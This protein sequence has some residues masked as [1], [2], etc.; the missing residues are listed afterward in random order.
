MNKSKSKCIFIRAGGITHQV[1]YQKNPGGPNGFIFE[2]KGNSQKPQQHLVNMLGALS[3]RVVPQ[4]SNLDLSVNY[5]GFGS[6]HI[7]FL[8][9]GF[10]AVL[11]IERDNLYAEEVFGHTTKDY[12]YSIKSEITGRACLAYCSL[13]LSF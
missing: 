8:E 1:G 13:S 11:L 5:H 2:T 7:S 9:D 12:D 6:D 10:P 4:T 3:H